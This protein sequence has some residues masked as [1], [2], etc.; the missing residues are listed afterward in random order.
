MVGQ[1]VSVQRLD[2]NTGMTQSHLRPA[3]PWAVGLALAAVYVIW[4]STYLAIAVMVQTLPPLVAGGI[5]YTIAGL[6]VLAAIAAWRRLT[7][8]GR[9]VSHQRLGWPQFGAALL[10]GALLLLGGNGGVVIGETL[11]PSGV[12]AVIIATT[13]IWIAVLGSI[14]DR[15]LPGPL[16]LAGLAGGLVGVVL[17]LAPSSEAALDP[18]GVGLVALAAISWSIGSTLSPWVPLPKSVFT[19]AGLEML[20]GG[21]MLITVGV[22]RGELDGLDPATFSAPSVWATVYLILIG[23]LVAFTAYIWL[24]SHAPINLVSTYAYVN[25]VVAVILGVVILDE[26]LTPQMLLAAAIIVVSVVAIVSG[27]PRSVPAEPDVA[28]AM[29]S[30]E[31]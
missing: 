27:R 31:P 29:G 4:G 22:L 2:D 1:S 24:L 26:S 20:F 11:I 28:V 7:A 21:L 8:A 16:V 5:R 13:P 3:S 9:A 23:S 19:G 17:L 25:P 14:V 12:A 15:R 6:V 10:I 18:L 30:G